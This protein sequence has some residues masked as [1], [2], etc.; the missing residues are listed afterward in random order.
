MAIF[1][2]YVSLP[3]GICLSMNYSSIASPSVARPYSCLRKAGFQHLHVE[4][5]QV[6]ALAPDVLPDLRRGKAEKPHVVT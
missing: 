5:S 4:Q 6:R 1:T 2:S 3:E